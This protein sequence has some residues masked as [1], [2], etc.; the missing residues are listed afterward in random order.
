MLQ[1]NTVQAQL[2]IAE[3]LVQG[4]EI[5]G[6]ERMHIVTVD[7]DGRADLVS[8]DMGVHLHRAEGFCLQGDVHLGT[9]Q[10]LQKL[11][12]AG[13]LRLQAFARVPGLQAGGQVGIIPRGQTRE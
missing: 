3:G 4:G 11:D 1:R 13:H 5:A 7:G 12:R 6:Q 2:A 8:A 9:S 10:F